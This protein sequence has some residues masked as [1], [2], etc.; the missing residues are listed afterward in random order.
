MTGYT[1]KT[2]SSAALIRSWAAVQAA[3]GAT[4]AALIGHAGETRLNA[5]HVEVAMLSA[6]AVLAL[7]SAIIYEDKA[8]KSFKQTWLAAGALIST[9][10]ISR[11]LDLF[12]NHL[13]FRG[14]VEVRAGLWGVMGIATLTAWATIGAL[15]GYEKKSR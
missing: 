9:A 8:F 13:E 11:S 6:G 10:M 5:H 15:V 14:T 3:A 12:W 7:V 4:L 1:T 2:T